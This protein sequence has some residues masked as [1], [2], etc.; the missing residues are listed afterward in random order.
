MIPE[1]SMKINEEVLESQKESR[2]YKLHKDK[3]RI[4]GYVNGLEAMEQAILLML[5]TVRF[6][7][8]IYS[9]DYGID[10]Q[11]LIGQHKTYAYPVLAKRIR[12][13][14]LKDDRINEVNSF[15]Y[16]PLK[17][18]ISLSFNVETVY[19]DVNVERQVS[20]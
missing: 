3:K 11:S 16:E 1:L 6:E 4:S 7:H 18:G 14:L 17:G 12:D 19:G 2:T 10:I 8:V 15:R 5:E 20:I 9:W 13:A